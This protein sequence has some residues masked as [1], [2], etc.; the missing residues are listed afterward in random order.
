MSTETEE[1]RYGL[2]TER[3]VRADAR[4]RTRVSLWDEYL[5][6]YRMDE[7]INQHVAGDSGD[8]VV[9]S[10]YFYA[11]SR[12]IL[13]SVYYRNP[14]ILV[15][16]G[17]NT[18]PVFARIVE[19]LL[20]YQA[21]ELRYE[22]E[23]RDAVFDALFCGVGVTKQGYA[24]ALVKTGR[25]S[26]M[27]FQSVLEDLFEEKPETDEYDQRVTDVNPFIL[28]VSPRH[29][30]IDPLATSLMD[31]RWVAHTV[32][33]PVEEVKD[34]GKYS[35]ALVSGIQGTHTGSDELLGNAAFTPFGMQSPHDR[36]KDEELVCLYEIW[37]IENRKLMVM[38]SYNLIRG[39][40]KFLREEDWPYPVEG[41]PFNMLVFNHDPESPWG[42]PDAS[43]WLNPIMALNML[44]T[45]RLRHVR[46]FNRKYGVTKGQI[47]EGELAKM[48]SNED[49]SV[50]YT[51][52]PLAQAVGV[53][54]DA[55]ITGDLY[56]LEAS[57]REDLTLLAGLTEQ[58]KGSSDRAKTATEASIMESRA[59]IRDSDRLYLVSKWVE[60]TFRKQHQFNKAYLKPD[61]VSFL[62]VP[63]AVQLWKEESATIL[64]AEMDVRVRVGSSSYFSREVRAKQTLDFLNLTQ[65]D[66]HVNREVLLR[67][68]AEA[69][70]LEAPQEF[71]ITQPMYTL[72]QAAQIL[73]VMPQ[74]GPGGPGD[75]P[76]PQ[77]TA[78]RNGGTNLGDQLSG[79][80]NL[81]ARPAP[82]PTMQSGEQ[83]PQEAMG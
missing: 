46:R 77:D 49:G 35:K 6:H 70:D 20:N 79:I 23:A 60:D 57:L 25:K 83:A 34:S 47:D 74:G 42:I 2:W 50:F 4:M 11:Y 19:L 75:M 51:N 3:M 15:S 81:G 29:F 67:R 61:Y 7:S 48:T 9:W 72:E 28:R 68:V 53:L 44:R 14:E 55:P 80:Q 82:N 39:E 59:Q 30:R 71:I 22:S 64:A 56:N 43:T 1:K 33:K 31:A 8:D 36:Y 66:P 27:S 21:R 62:T 41:F 45:M 10:N 54:P 69:M 13:P 18:E 12:I 63:E 58:R 17:P 24:P 16:P 52:S 40:R 78:R 73:G 65:G 26:P 37:D 38:D 32:W 76:P 5:A